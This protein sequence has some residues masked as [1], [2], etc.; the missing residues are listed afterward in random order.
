MLRVETWKHGWRWVYSVTYDAGVRSLLEHALPLHRRHEMPGAVALD[1]A[2]LANGDEQRQDADSG[3][4]DDY[5][6]LDDVRALCRQ[7]WSVAG[8][9]AT[10]D[11]G[12]RAPTRG[13]PTPAARNGGGAAAR[14]NRATTSD[15]RAPTR[16]APT[17]GELEQLVGAPVTV[18]AVSTIDHYHG[19]LPEE[20]RAAGYLAIFTREDR[21]NHN[22]V[23]EDLY[24]LGRSALYTVEG[25]PLPMRTYDPYWRLH[26]ARDTA[27]WLVDSARFVAED[28]ADPERDVTPALLAERFEKV[29]EVGGVWRAAPAEVIDYLLMRRAAHPRALRASAEAITFTMEAPRIPQ[30]VRNRELTFTLDVPRA[31]ERPA[32]TCDGAPVSDVTPIAEG[33]IRFTV[34]AADGQRMRVS[35]ASDA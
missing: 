22:H 20:A 32:V 2:R 16:V 7:G 5:L 17:A 13:A 31:W 21:L 6:T 29:A 18:L 4:G 11:G 15:S 1:A 30:R 35:A 26:Q 25:L 9:G 8:F 19:I 24:A 12:G 23:D 14:D 3:P 27:G 34:A 28:P 33:R 10:G